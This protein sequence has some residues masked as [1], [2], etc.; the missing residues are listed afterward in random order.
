MTDWRQWLVAVTAFSNSV[1]LPTLGIGTP[2][3]P[4][5]PGAA[6]LMLPATIMAMIAFSEASWKTANPATIALLAST[7]WM[8]ASA[9]QAP[10][11]LSGVVRGGWFFVAAFG[12]LWAIDRIGYLE[13]LRSLV[14]GVLVFIVLGVV[15]YPIAEV[16]I[17]SE[18]LFDQPIFPW[19]RLR[20]IGANQ[21][22]LGFS[23]VLCVVALLG[24]RPVLHLAVRAGG[25]GVGIGAILLSHNRGAMGSLVVGLG[26]FVLPQLWHR[27]QAAAIAVLAGLAGL[28]VI[29]ATAGIRPMT[30]RA[31]AEDEISY[32]SSTE[33][34]V[35]TGR[36]EVWAAAI[37]HGS[38]RPLTGRGNGS[39]SAH[40]A[41]EFELLR[42]SWDPTHAHNTLFEVFADQG[43]VG[44][45]VFVG[46]LALAVRPGHRFDSSGAAIVAACIAHGVVE[47]T[48][49]GSPSSR[50][51]FLVVAIAGVTANHPGSEP[52][53]A[54]DAEGVEAECLAGIKA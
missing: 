6:V 44:I 18:D 20:G 10:E 54:D 53:G 33:G 26:V 39:F 36:G 9:L 28:G 5:L 21:T 30:A 27:R 22:V 50:W 14:I 11:P 47:A 4:S 31:V 2:G 45:V 35:F 15:L 17:P 19:P 49:Y 51:M 23:G 38:S 37:E 32:W 25:I 41:E 7:A 52:G 12:F 46:A 1:Y 16:E 24:L 43:I 40:T 3:D 8:S 29:I 34:D 13:T 48:F 42:S